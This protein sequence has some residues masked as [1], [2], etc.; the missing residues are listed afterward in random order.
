MLPPGLGFNAIS[1]KA[2]A[3]SKSN[4]FRRSYWNWDEILKSNATRLLALHP[5]N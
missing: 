2:I 1:D 5:G 3:A 4:K